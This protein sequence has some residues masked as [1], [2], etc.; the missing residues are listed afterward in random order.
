MCYRIQLTM[1]SVWSAEMWSTTLEWKSVLFNMCIDFLFVGQIHWLK[2]LLTLFECNELKNLSSF[3]A[4][5]KSIPICIL[6]N[7]YNKEMITFCIKTHHRMGAF[8][9]FFSFQNTY[10][11]YSHSQRQ[12]NHWKMFAELRYVPYKSNG[13]CFRNELCLLI[14]YVRWRVFQVFLLLNVRFF[15]LHENV[16]LL[17]V[18]RTKDST[19]AAIIFFFFFNA[20]LLNTCR[21]LKY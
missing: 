2:L 5:I 17:K 21:L 4:V 12:Q 20:T 14:V 3:W 10:G 13:F 8:A 11:A 18:F 19:G 7:Q 6:Q 1:Y 15:K 16:I 9:I